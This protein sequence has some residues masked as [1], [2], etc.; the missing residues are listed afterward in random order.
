MPLQDFSTLPE[1]FLPLFLPL[2]RPEGQVQVAQYSSRLLEL[3][4]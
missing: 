4:L 1:G 2:L 3:E